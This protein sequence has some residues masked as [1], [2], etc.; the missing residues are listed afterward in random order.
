MPASPG[1]ANEALL[2]AEIVRLNKI[3]DV[4]MDRAESGSNRFDA[5]FGLQ[6]TTILLE[7]Q[8]RLRTAEL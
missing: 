1:Q 3:I 6:Q 2:Q 4:L 8:V 5:D 7:D